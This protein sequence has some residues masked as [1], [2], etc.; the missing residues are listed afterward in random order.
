VWGPAD[1]QDVL[2]CCSIGGLHVC[3][4]VWGVVRSHR[5]VM[6][7]VFGDVAWCRVWL[8]WCLAD[9]VS[10]WCGVACQGMLFQNF[11][12]SDR[13]LGS[14]LVD[15]RRAY[16]PFADG[17]HVAVFRRVLGFGVGRQCLMVVGIYLGRGGHLWSR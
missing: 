10:G 12:D 17:W 6:C 3:V 5:L 14:C 1:H 8:V 15:L 9:V 11:H 2:L 16:R 7:A 13:L 4:S